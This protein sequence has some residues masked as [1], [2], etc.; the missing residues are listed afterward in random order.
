M[1]I[2]F[3]LISGLL[4]TSL[5]MTQDTI[6]VATFCHTYGDSIAVRWQPDGKIGWELG[7]KHGYKL[8]RLA[9]NNEKLIETKSLGV[10]TF[11]PKSKWGYLLER[12]PYACL[13]YTSPSPRD[14]STSRMPSSA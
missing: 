9:Y 10:F 6:S 8:T 13:L 2:I 12:N 5:A 1:K 14:L 11:L 4:F 7:K 3:L